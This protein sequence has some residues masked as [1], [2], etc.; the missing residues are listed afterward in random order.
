MG[1]LHLQMKKFDVSCQQ[2][3]CPCLYDLGKSLIYESGSTL[4]LAAASRLLICSRECEYNSIA[5]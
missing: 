4:D 1:I 5:Q 3:G 2:N